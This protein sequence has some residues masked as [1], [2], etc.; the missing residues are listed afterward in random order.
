M[1]MV[2]WKRDAHGRL[3]KTTGYLHFEYWMT[4]SGYYTGWEGLWRF[5]MAQR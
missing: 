4:A 2:Q 5:R 3:V 1:I